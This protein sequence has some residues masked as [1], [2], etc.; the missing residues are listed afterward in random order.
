MSKS[1]KKLFT[2]V[3]RLE[4]VNLVTRVT[5]ELSDGLG[6]KDKTVAEFVVTLAEKELK[7]F[8]K[9]GSP[10]HVTVE[11]AQSLRKTLAENGAPE[12]PL[13][14]VSLIL[15]LVWK[16]S[17]TIARFQVKLLKKRDDVLLKDGGLGGHVLSSSESSIRKKELGLSFPG[18][19]KPNLTHAV[20]L[21]KDFYEHSPQQ[22]EH[23]RGSRNVSNLPAWMSKKRPREDDTLKPDLHGIYRGTIK[24]ILDFGMVVELEG[25]FPPNTEGIVPLAEIT[26]NRVASASEAGFF[27][28]QCVWVKVL[29]NRHDR[30]VLSTNDVD[31]SNGKDLMPHRS[32]AYS[33]GDDGRN[34]SSHHYYRGLVVDPLKKRKVEEASRASRLVA[35]NSD[36]GPTVR[37]KKQ[38]TEHELF[39][40]QQLIRSGVHPVEQYQTKNPQ[41]VLG[42]LAV[43]H[44]EEDID[45][46]VAEKEPSS[47]RGQTRRSG[48]DLE[49]KKILKSPTGPLQQAVI[50]PATLAIERRDFRHA[51]ENQLLDSIPNDRIPSSE[52]SMTEAGKS[53]CSVELCSVPV[54][55]TQPKATHHRPASSNLN[56]L[57]D[58]AGLTEKR[59]IKPVLVSFQAADNAN[60]TSHG[61]TKFLERPMKNQRWTELTAVGQILADEVLIYQYENQPKLSWGEVSQLRSWSQSVQNRIYQQSTSV[62]ENV[63][64]ASEMRHKLKQI[65]LMRDDLMVLR[66]QAKKFRDEA[67]LMEDDA[68]KTEQESS[69][70]ESASQFLLAVQSLKECA[71]EEKT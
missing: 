25:A 20:P 35:M 67:A 31:Q 17:P 68:R 9:K 40:V 49:S 6:I 70:L 19:T 69:L 5:A 26:G 57:A 27:S 58:S 1:E 65:E 38:L 48:R 52:D 42:M 64:L 11:L 59:R 43:E 61:S 18:L 50:Q 15:D 28:N 32:T 2:A 13:S 66:T 55:S 37:N 45:V 30:L 24:K 16:S 8:L 23:S 21:D 29:H 10:T 39:D 33:E 36:G 47:L 71:C 53:S 46:E 12:V 34:S 3:E 56:R 63:A 54:G 22:L 41:G 62:L 14:L 44:S 51:Q 4:A 60:K 7:S